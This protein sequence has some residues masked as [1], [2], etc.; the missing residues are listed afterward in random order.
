MDIY[1]YVEENPYSPK[2]E[3]SIRYTQKFYDIFNY[4]ESSYRVYEAR[5]FGL[6]FAQ[7]LRMT[8]DL[9]GGRII[10][11]GHKYPRVYFPEKE[12]AQK[13]ARELNN[14]LTYVLKNLNIK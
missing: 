13:L 4:T 6:S 14:R 3:Y 1:F 2:K 7:Y 8:R 11:T 5:L 12:K 9:Y 10:G